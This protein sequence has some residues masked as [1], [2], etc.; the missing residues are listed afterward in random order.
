MF[1]G[2]GWLTDSGMALDDYR[3][4][5][6]K[7]RHALY[8]TNIS[9]EKPERFTELNYLYHEMYSVQ[10]GY[11]V[12]MMFATRGRSELAYLTVKCRDIWFEDNFV[13]PDLHK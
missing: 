6:R 1:K 12:H 5:F 2:Y 4:V 8:I 10:D 7:C 9:K 13:L 11:E 3:A